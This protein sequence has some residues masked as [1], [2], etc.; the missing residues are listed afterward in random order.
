METEFAVPVAAAENRTNEKQMSNSFDN[1][2]GQRK[3][4]E[5]ICKNQRNENK[6]QN[7]KMKSNIFLLYM[8]QPPDGFLMV[9]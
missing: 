9:S 8:H 7:Q 5:N 2:F 1:Q 3:V 6:N 4:C